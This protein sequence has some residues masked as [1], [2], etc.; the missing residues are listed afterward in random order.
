M[1]REFVTGLTLICLLAALPSAANESQTKADLAAVQAELKKSQAAYDK[2]KKSFS[3]LKERLQSFELEIAKSA[4][5]L[6]FTKQGI[7]ENKQQQY[8][9]KTE[10]QQLNRRKKN[11][12][13][14]LAAQLKSAYVTGS[15]DYSKMLLNQQKTSA[16]ERTISYYDYFNKARINQ[17]E[18]LKDIFLE[19]EKNQQ[20]LEKVQQQLIE[21]LAQQQVRQNELQL[22]QKQR[23]THLNNLNDKLQQTQSA[24]AYLEENET[25]LKTTLEALAEVQAPSEEVFIAQLDG[26]RRLKGKLAW[27]H[28]GRLTKRFGQRKHAGMSWKGVMIAG[29]NGDEISSVAPGHVVYADWMNGFG[30]VIVLDHGEGFMSL[31]GHAQTLLRDVGDHV[32]PGDPIALVGQSGGQQIPGLYFEIRHKGSAVNPVKWCRSS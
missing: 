25:T 8:T 10:G 15:H 7:S 26:L 5:A 28:K 14:L 13:R 22:A 29:K 4:K 19:L 27:P 30:W 2:Q 12:Q 1:L 11:L 16:L 20:A 17:L 18:D 31:Y 6:A 32:N 21:L 3:S 9:L 24:I 23:Q